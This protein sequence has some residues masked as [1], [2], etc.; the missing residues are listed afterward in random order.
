MQA[1]KKLYIPLMFFCALS[2]ILGVGHSSGAWAQSNQLPYGHLD[3]TSATKINGW[4]YDPDAGTS[5]VDVEIY[6]DGIAGSGTLAF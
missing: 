3:G 2:I 6:F 5:P 4:G 1:M